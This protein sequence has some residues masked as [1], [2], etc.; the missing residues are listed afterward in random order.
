MKDAKVVI[1]NHDVSHKSLSKISKL[2]HKHIREDSQ[3]RYTDVLELV[4]RSLGYDSS[5]TLYDSVARSPHLNFAFDDDMNFDISVSIGL[6]LSDVKQA[7][8]ESVIQHL[9]D[10]LDFEETFDRLNL[11]RLEFFGSEVLAS[12]ITAGYISDLYDHYLHSSVTN[13]SCSD[14]DDLQDQG[15]VS[16]GYNG[17]ERYSHDLDLISLIGSSS[18]DD[19]NEVLFE[20]RFSDLM[21]LEVTVNDGGGPLDGNYEDLIFNRTHDLTV[22]A[23]MLSYANYN[24]RQCSTSQRVFDKIS[25]KLK[26]KFISDFKDRDSASLLFANVNKY[27]FTVGNEYMERTDHWHNESFQYNDVKISFKKRDVEDASSASPLRGFVWR[28]EIESACGRL[29]AYVSGGCYGFDIEYYN[30]P[31][32][33]PHFDDYGLSR[34]SLLHDLIDDP[35]IEIKDVSDEVLEA[36]YESGTGFYPGAPFIVTISTWDHGNLGEEADISLLINAC[37][38]KLKSDMG[39]VR[40]FTLAAPIQYPHWVSE[41][42]YSPTNY[43]RMLDVESE[44][45]FLEEVLDWEHHDGITPPELIFDFRGK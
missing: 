43:N 22:S 41:F 6:S 26:N 34:E 20:M 17:H 27:G 30:E 19:A 36:A 45:S 14:A 39:N 15:K 21:K 4:V 33:F 35:N 11:K 29:I 18:E 28:A 1:T 5:K 8:K 9:R 13:R 25:A 40:V 12:N 24:G 2:L 44:R 10:P 23:A 32:Q 42:Y 16:C 38:D 7:L 37:I 3:L 31:F